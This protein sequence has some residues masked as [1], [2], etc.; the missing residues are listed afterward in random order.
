MLKLLLTEH[1]FNTAEI[2]T[3]V[4]MANTGSSSAWKLRYM[5]HMVVISDSTHM[6]MTNKK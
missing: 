3:Q 5:T 4:G 1:Q 6:T 2:Q